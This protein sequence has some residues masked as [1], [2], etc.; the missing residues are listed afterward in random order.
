MKLKFSISILLLM[1]V[2]TVVAKGQGKKKYPTLKLREVEHSLQDCPELRD[3]EDSANLVNL[4]MLY[5]R[6]PYCYKGSEL[7]PN[8]D[9][10]PW[11]R[12]RQVKFDYKMAHSKVKPFM[13]SLRIMLPVAG[14]ARPCVKLSSG[15]DVDMRGY[16][17]SLSCDVAI[18]P[19]LPSNDRLDGLI[20]GPIDMLGNTRLKFTYYLNNGD[21][22]N[23]VLI[24]G[25][26]S[27]MTKFSSIASEPKINQRLNLNIDADDAQVASVKVFAIAPYDDYQ[28]IRVDSSSVGKQY[29]LSGVEFTVTAFANGVVHLRTKNSN[30]MRKLLEDLKLIISDRGVLYAEKPGF[31]GVYEN[32]QMHQVDKFLYNLSF[33]SPGMD[34]LQFKKA[35]K[36]GYFSPL[37]PMTLVIGSNYAFD[38]MYLYKQNELVVGKRDMLIDRSDDQPTYYITDSDNVSRAVQFEGGSEITAAEFI[39][40][41]MGETVFFYS[42]MKMPRAVSADGP[43]VTVIVEATITKEGKIVEAEA[44]YDADPSIK[45]EA[46]RL[47]NLSSGMWK[48]ASVNGENIDDNQFIIISFDRSQHDIIKDMV[49]KGYF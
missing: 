14:A 42:N 2:I 45:K 10:L 7:Q 48:P 43:I 33:N 46:L 8:I 35:L 28:F 18:E 23:K 49:K 20:T 12:S 29:E 17:N 44:F 21:V 11:L 1:G 36:K 13:D 40:G 41:R 15:F 37:D 5:D 25:V 19:F 4:Y 26:D 38:T 32:S 27:C 39:G 47:I 3:D 6:L 24:V 30:D 22:D 16:S 34:I 31:S 9:T